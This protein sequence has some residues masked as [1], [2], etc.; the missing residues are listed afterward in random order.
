MDGII[1][2]K[3]PLSGLVDST[4]AA[5]TDGLV[6]LIQIIPKRTILRLHKLKSVIRRRQTS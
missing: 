6:S 2:F 1:S 4:G 5:I 3:K